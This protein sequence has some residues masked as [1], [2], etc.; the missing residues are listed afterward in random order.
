ME[1]FSQP[2]PRMNQQLPL[3]CFHDELLDVQDL[4][5]E[6][7]SFPQILAR[8]TRWSFEELADIVTQP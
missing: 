6:A 8:E 7:L 4:D 5:I 2:Q 1:T 3:T